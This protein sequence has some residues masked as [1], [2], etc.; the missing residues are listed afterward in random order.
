MALNYP[1][2]LPVWQSWQGLLKQDR[3]TGALLLNAPQGLGV[4]EVVTEFSRAVACVNSDDEAC[5]FCHSCELSLSGNHPD[6][7]WIKPEKAGKAITV[8]QIRQCNLWAQ[9]SSQLG[10]KRLIIIEPAEAMNES[11]SNALLKTL[12]SPSESC[13]FLLVTFNKH[14]LLPTITSRCQ[15]W[16][17]DNPSESDALEWLSTQ[18]DVGVSADILRL[19][20]GAPLTTLAFY[21]DKHDKA[22]QSLSAG[23]IGELKKPV[24]S[25]SSLWPSIKEDPLVRLGWISYL[26]VEVQKYH[27]GLETSDPVPELARFVSY[28]L[29][30]KKAGDLNELIKKMTQFTGLNSE[31][32]WAD[33]VLD[34]HGKR[35]VC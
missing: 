31:L 27:F 22:Y 7:H 24:M 17:V 8:D 10:G 29:A 13:V 18:S 14:Q 9:E 30:Y 11:S 4:D 34:L 5:G 15:L 1:W 2:L 12:E 19:C 3:L 32:L 33:W 21:Q 23:L 25:L 35:N 6:I 16:N 26:L 28:D 20:H